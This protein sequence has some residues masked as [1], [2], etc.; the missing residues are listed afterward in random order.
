MRQISRKI[1]SLLRRHYN[2]NYINISNV[3]NKSLWNCLYL[4]LSQACVFLLPKQRDVISRSSK[5][6]IGHVYYTEAE[7]KERD[8]YTI[9]YRSRL[10]S[11]LAI[12]AGCRIDTRKHVRTRD[13]IVSTSHLKPHGSGFRPPTN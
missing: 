11:S 6:C 7:A 10:A 1:T 4:A 2:S 5:P 12:S 9:V 13:N 8:P 3:T